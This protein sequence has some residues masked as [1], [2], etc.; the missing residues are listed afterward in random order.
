MISYQSSDIAG[1]SSVTSH[2]SSVSHLGFVGLAAAA[3]NE[4]NNDDDDDGDAAA[5]TQTDAY[6]GEGLGFGG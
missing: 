5:D 1:Q 4:D 2:R 3:E 6:G